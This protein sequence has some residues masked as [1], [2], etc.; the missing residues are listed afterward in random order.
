MYGNGGFM[1]LGGIP[2]VAVESVL[3][4]IVMISQHQAVSAHL[5]HDGGRRYGYAAGIAFNYRLMGQIGLN[6]KIAVY[7]HKIRP[8]AKIG[9]RHDHGEFGGLENIDPVDFKGIH[10][11]DT[12]RLGLI[13]DMDAEMLSLAGRQLLGI[14]DIPGFKIRRQ[15]HGSGYDRAGQGT[16]AGLIHSGNLGVTLGGQ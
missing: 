14:G 7:K 4:E 13:V 3:G 8:R 5:G 6:T 15:D 1:R 12:N 16:S 9:Q 11:A 10:N 2:F